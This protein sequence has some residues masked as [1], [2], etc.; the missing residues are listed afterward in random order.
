MISYKGIVS[1]LNLCQQNQKDFKI[2]I[3]FLF[4]KY[5]ICKIDEKRQVREL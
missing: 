4:H 5:S 3:D 1:N 2:I